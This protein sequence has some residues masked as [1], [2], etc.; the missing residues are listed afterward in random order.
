MSA[1]FSTSITT[2]PDGLGAA[3]GTYVN[4]ASY[5]AAASTPTLGIQAA[6]ATGKD[7][8]L[9][10]FYN[11]TDTLTLRPGQ[12][13]FSSDRTVGGLIVS[14]T[15]NPNATAIITSSGGE[16]GPEL[17]DMG[18]VCEQ[19]TDQTSRS[20]FKTLTDG[21]TSGVGGSGVKYPPVVDFSND[22]RF[23]LSGIRITGAWD[24]IKAMGNAGG[25][26]IKNVEI[27]ALNQ[28]LTMDG[29]LD[30]VHVEGYHFWPFGI[31]GTP[32]MSVYEDGQTIAASFGRVDGL[33]VTNF[34]TFGGRV[35][36]LAD[37]TYA[38]MTSVD[39]DG[40][41]STLEVAGG[42]I[43][44]T[45]LYTTKDVAQTRPSVIV[46]GGDLALGQAAF[47]GTSSA[48]LLQVTGGSAIV[49]DGFLSQLNPNYSAAT[50]SGGS[51]MLQAMRM[52]PGNGTYTSGYIAQSGTGVINVQG[53]TFGA[54]T[55]KAVTIGTD[56]AGNVVA[57]NSFATGS[58]TV[59]AGK[60]VGAY[61]PNFPGNSHSTTPTLITYKLDTTPPVAPVIT[62]LGSVTNQ[63]AQTLVGMGAEAGST[64]SVLDGTALLGTATAA[65][66][67]T[68]SVSAILAD[69]GVH[70]VTVT[71][72]DAAGRV[73]QASGPVSFT[74]DTIAPAL[75]LSTAETASPAF[76]PAVTPYGSMIVSGTLVSGGAASIAGQMVTL[77]NNGVAV[78]T[79]MPVVTDA[80][81]QFS[82]TI[83]LPGSSNSLVASSQDSAGNVTSSA[84]LSAP[85]QMNT[86]VFGS[87]TSD[88]TSIGG[89]VYGLY[90]AVL[91]RAPDPI[92]FEGWVDAANNGMTLTSVAQSMLSSAEYTS[93]YG[94]V[95]QRNPADFVSTL[96][97]NALGRSPEADGLQS[98]TSMLSQGATQAQVAAWI[99]LSP[100]SIGRMQPTFLAPGGV[101]VPDEG[102]ASV[103]RLY[104]GL[105]GRMPDSSGLQFFETHVHQGWSLADVAEGMIAAPEYLTKSGTL[106][107]KQFVQALYTNALG[108]V[109]DPEGRQAWTTALDYGASRASV[110]IGIAESQEAHSHLAPA[111]E[112]GF[113]VT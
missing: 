4:A 65:W 79:A 90:E 9:P 19:P 32:L 20:A 55:G 11:I 88:P 100:E 94:A 56:Q 92:G 85:S 75:T 40:D 17:Q 63:A 111:I 86:L 30:F 6:L 106:S 110:A 105:L 13:L 54:M 73:S 10:T 107:N 43:N 76:N 7:V 61:G 82:V 47:L 15:F 72:T 36:M 3:A 71:D 102:A 38:T 68:W 99:A 24:A 70:S 49:A 37:S 77:T 60:L 41:G 27:G 84:P 51:L 35:L 21:G 23:T 12:R 8:Y 104:Y 34:S 62:S 53:N 64:V 45:S 103:A 81:G 69:D 80:Q 50:V 97:A 46:T 112:L 101:F 74:L 44:V 16:P 66:D 39:L 91:G 28:G 83:T 58:I 108:R 1:G 29:S 5:V 48:E 113:K 87:T 33:S 57:N 14:D 95:A 109:A 67:G 2:S 26:W 96:Y 25:A 59:P 93:D 42:I 31:A 18:I 52:V 89:Q 78:A 22:P 98:W